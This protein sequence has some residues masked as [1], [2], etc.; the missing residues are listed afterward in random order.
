MNL[1]LRNIQHYIEV[2]IYL[3]HTFI[4]ALFFSLFIFSD[5]FS[6]TVNDTLAKIFSSSSFSLLEDYAGDWGGYSH[7]FLFTKKDTCIEILWQD[8]DFPD[9]EVPREL[10]IVYPLSELKPIET[11]FT[12]CIEKISSSKDK[13]T[14]HSKYIFKNKELTF[15][16]DDRSTMTCVDDLKAWKEKLF[17]E[18]ITQEK[19][20]KKK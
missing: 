2:R 20:N 19:R 18:G 6:Q 3:K 7:T 17:K 4:A 8:P 12:N 5:S 11:I 15:T 1:I 10:K 13:S 16:I 9:G 14:E